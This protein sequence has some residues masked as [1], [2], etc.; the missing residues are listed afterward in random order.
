MNCLINISESTDYIVF[1]VRGAK[2]NQVKVVGTFEDPWFCGKDV[3]EI[4][5][6]SNIKKVLWELV[7]NEYKKTLKELSEGLVP[8]TG[9]NPILG[10][11]NLSVKHPVCQA[12][13]INEPGLYSLIMARKASVERMCARS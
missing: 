12:V 13:Y 7:E 6:Y 5:E 8:A 4:L 9:T 11:N 3:C 2:K 10:R 1:D